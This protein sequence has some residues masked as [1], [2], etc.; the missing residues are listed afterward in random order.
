M[1]CIM[2]STAVTGCWKRI[3][4]PFHMWSLSGKKLS[5]HSERKK[6]KKSPYYG[7]EPVRNFMSQANND[8][9]KI[10]YQ[11]NCGHRLRSTQAR[12]CTEWPT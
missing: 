12:P 4:P 7:T 5:L 10:N 1:K 9:D 11:N 3:F 8:G 2:L 6:K